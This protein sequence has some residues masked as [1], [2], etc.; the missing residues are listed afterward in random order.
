MLVRVCVDRR[1]FIKLILKAFLKNSKCEN[2]YNNGRM[3]FAKQ[4][5]AEK[6]INTKQDSANLLKLCSV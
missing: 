2:E 3:K 5:M 1:L 6:L 4:Q